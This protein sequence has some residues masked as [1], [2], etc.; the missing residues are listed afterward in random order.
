MDQHAVGLIAAIAT[1]LLWTCSAVAWTAAGK[2]VGALAVCFLRLAITIVLLIAY[3]LSVHGA[4]L[5]TDADG[6]TWLVLGTSGF[7]GFFVS[8]LCLFRAF[9][10][11][12]PRLSLLVQTLSPPIAAVASA[13]LL[14]DALGPKEWLAMAVTLAG[15]AWVV[16]ERSES[17][18]AGAG[19]TGLSRCGRELRPLFRTGMLL[20]VV[21]A[22]AQALGLVLSKQGIGQYDDAVAATFIRVLGSMAGFL[23]LITLGRR[24]RPVLFAARHARAMSIMVFGSV[25]GPF[26]GVSLCM[27]ALRNSPAGVTATIIN[28]TPILILPLAVFLYQEKVTLRAAAGAMLSVAGVALLMI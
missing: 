19:E 28:T 6:R 17:E 1:A 3:G 26:L 18:N 7:L 24:W 13:V 15:I 21:A 4:W 10:L 16:L 27:V 12:G 2:H 25:V 14:R 8:D 9:L 5:P 22:V 11:I 23:P 20:S